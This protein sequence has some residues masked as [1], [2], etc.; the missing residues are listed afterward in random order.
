MLNKYDIYDHPDE[1]IIAVNNKFSWWGLLFG[2]LWLFSKGL[3]FRGFIFLFLAVLVQVLS[4]GPQ[5]VSS[6]GS[7][8]VSYIY[9]LISGLIIAS[10][11]HSWSNKKQ[12]LAKGYEFKGVI[13]AKS[14]SD[15]EKTKNV[16]EE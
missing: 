10:C 6:D 11:G 16:N 12:L 7:K 4:E 5:G 13:E 14:K 3:W 8:L 1:P 2:P 9:L 15:A